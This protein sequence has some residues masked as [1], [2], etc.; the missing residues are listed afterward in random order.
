MA[1][2][3]SN[4][5]NGKLGENGTFSIYWDCRF[6]IGVWSYRVLENSTCTSAILPTFAC[7]P[8]LPTFPFLS[9]LLA[10]KF[11]PLLPVPFLP[12]FG[13]D[14]FSVIVHQVWR[15]TQLF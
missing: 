3:G 6:G 11:V 12:Q 14:S 9:F 10:F 1:Y 13:T 15:K 8:F 7:L 2:V 5:I 4:G